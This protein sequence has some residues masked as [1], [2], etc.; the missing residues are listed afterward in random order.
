[1]VRIA[2]TNGATTTAPVFIDE[3]ATPA[4]PTG[5]L[6]LV[7]S[8]ALPTAVNAAG[9]RLTLPAANS[10]G[11]ASLANDGSQIA[12]VGMNLATG[13]TPTA[14]VCQAVVGTIDAYGN[15]DVSTSLGTGASPF[16]AGVAYGAATDNGTNFWVCGLSSG[17]VFHTRRG[18]RVTPAAALLDANAAGWSGVVAQV[19]NG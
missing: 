16:P 5:A 10:H 9:L 18:L 13:A 3:L 8:I 15:V 11:L 6:T 14:G 2:G 12:I 1:M 19:R 7:Q 17:G 4:T